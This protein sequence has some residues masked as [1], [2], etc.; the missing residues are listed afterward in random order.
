MVVLP[1]AGVGVGVGPVL[2]GIGPR[3]GQCALAVFIAFRGL[4]VVVTGAMTIWHAW[5]C[6]PGPETGPGRGQTCPDTG[7]CWCGH[8]FLG[9]HWLVHAFRVP[10]LVLLWHG[11]SDDRWPRA[12][13]MHPG[14]AC[15]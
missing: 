7:R 13:S 3:R 11:M 1:G 5:W 6:C 4:L 2:A 10:P 15:L 12:A 8:A 14:N 9:G